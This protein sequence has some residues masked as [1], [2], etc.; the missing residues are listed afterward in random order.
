MTDP[1]RTAPPDPKF[2][3]EIGQETWREAMARKLIAC[4]CTEHQARW[5]VGCGIPWTL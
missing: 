3:Q 4:G 1:P 2:L 5:L